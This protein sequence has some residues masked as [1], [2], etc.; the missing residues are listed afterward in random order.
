MGTN[1]EIRAYN[2]SDRVDVNQRDT[3][4]TRSSF[5]GSDD[6]VKGLS[7]INN[8]ENWLAI[9]R[10]LSQLERQQAHLMNMLQDFMG[11]SHNSMI[12]LDNRVRGLEKV[13]EDIAQELAG[14]SGRRPTTF[15]N[16]FEGSSNS[17]LGKYNDF[18]NYSGTKLGRA[19]DGRVTFSKRFLSSYSYSYNALRN[20]HMGSSR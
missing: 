13:V 15:M 17:I 11:G 5:S 19:S 8:K 2:A 20:G 7:F 14:S 18:P 16:T 4:S 3:S 12:T 1:S 9:Q 10:Q 6:H